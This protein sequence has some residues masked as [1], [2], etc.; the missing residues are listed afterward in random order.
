M[1][2]YPTPTPGDAA[3][4]DLSSLAGATYQVWVPALAG[5]VLLTRTLAE[6]QVQPLDVHTL[7]GPT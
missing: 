5:R 3:T 6:G 4:L 2:L 7:P 1:A